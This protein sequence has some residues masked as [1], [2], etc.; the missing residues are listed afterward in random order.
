MCS[1]MFFLTNDV[2]NGGMDRC[3]E[4]DMAGRV[5]MNKCVEPQL[6]LSVT[7]GKG[8]DEAEHHSARAEGSRRGGSGPA[9]FPFGRHHSP[10][11]LGV[12]GPFFQAQQGVAS[13]AE[14]QASDPIAPFLLRPGGREGGI[15]RGRK[16]GSAR[17]KH[18]HP[19]AEPEP[20]ASGSEGRWLLAA[21]ISQSLSTSLRS[22]PNRSCFP[23]HSPHLLWLLALTPPLPPKFPSPVSPPRPLRRSASPHLTR[24]TRYTCR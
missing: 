5:L 4:T 14:R 9:A 18:P 24:G 22:C 7:G 17:E 3:L 23:L 11:V 2:M 13:S 16:P 12:R 15:T 6:S 19:R 20:S 10:P 21:S 1:Y 8:S